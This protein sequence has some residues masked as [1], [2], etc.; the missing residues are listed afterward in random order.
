MFKSR[1]TEVMQRMQTE[2]QISSMFYNMVDNTS[3]SYEDIR[4][5]LHEQFEDENGFIDSLIDEEICDSKSEQRGAQS[6]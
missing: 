3:L 1:T 2:Q 5:R 6:L 4:M